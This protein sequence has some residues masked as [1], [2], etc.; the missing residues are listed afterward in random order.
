MKLGTRLAGLELPNPVLVCSGTFGTGDEY[1]SLLDVSALGGIFSKAV[2]LEPCSG[3]PPPRIWETP[4]GMLN[5]IGLQNKG[6]DAF[7]AE[8]LPRL[9]GHGVP[10]IV[11]VAGFSE[12]EYVET[13]SRLDGVAG[14]SGLEL[15]VSCPNVREGG[16]HFGL[17]PEQLGN[18][19]G[20][21]RRACSL[22]LLVKLSPQVADIGSMGRTAAAAGADG[23]SLV[24]TFPGMAVDVESWKP[25]LANITGGLSGP[26]VHPLAVRAVWEAARSVDLPIVAMGGI[27]RW[28]D[29]VEMFLVGASAVAVGTAL[30][31]NPEAPLD[32]LR[33]I[34]EYLERKGVGGLRGLI[35][36]VR[37]GE[38]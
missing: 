30:F 8:D 20:A 31:S 26:A 19:V 14:V 24:N 11:N 3:N 36:K 10:V 13:A 5:A 21:V 35:G 7:L 25:R 18:L 32:I 37:L 34:E 9:L 4:S 6:L 12:E 38:A 17:D 16:I 15:N 1:G 23:L 2:T 27:S 28:E 22:P 29:A 33:G